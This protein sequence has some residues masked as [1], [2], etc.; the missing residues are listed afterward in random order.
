MNQPFPLKDPTDYDLISSLI[1]NDS[2]AA[3]GSTPDYWDG[4]I[5]TTNGVNVVSTVKSNNALPA[6][7]D[8][9]VFTVKFMTDSLQSQ[10]VLSALYDHNVYIYHCDPSMATGIGLYAKQGQYDYV[11]DLI[12]YGSSTHDGRAVDQVYG[13]GGSKNTPT[14]TCDCNVLGLSCASNAYMD[15]SILV[16]EFGHTVM[17]V[18]LRYG[19]PTLYSSLTGDIFDAYRSGV[20]GATSAYCGSTAH[21]LWAC[22]VQTWLVG[23][24]R[25]D[26]NPG[27]S[28]VDDIYYNLQPLYNALYNTFG[29]P[30]KHRIPSL[31]SVASLSE[32]TWTYFDHYVNSYGDASLK[33]SWNAIKY[34]GSATD[35]DSENDV[36]PTPTPPTPTP[37]PTNGEVLSSDF[38]CGQT[39]SGSVVAGEYSYH[40]FTYTGGGILMYPCGQTY[41]SSSLRIIDAYWNAYGDDTSSFYEASCDLSYDDS[42]IWANSGLV[43]GSSYW[44][45]VEGASSEDAG[46]YGVTMYCYDAGA[47]TVTLGQEQIELGNGVSVTAL[48]A[49]VLITCVVSLAVMCVVVKVVTERKME[50]FVRA[51]SNAKAQ[52][53]SKWSVPDKEES[54]EDQEIEVD[55]DMQTQR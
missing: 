2:A 7:L 6:A 36:T 37:P 25:S 45:I 28:T 31:T 24:A 55:V 46:Q 8:I 54:D 21:E 12:N 13:Y 18:G 42:V 34:T 14:T 23:T 5:R 40:A 50:A 30:A 4:A 52:S 10:S 48:V 27:I 11:S 43:V 39:V 41:F 38:G 22:G 19:N 35:D 47:L 26:V 53:A 20:S 33:G 1:N 3:L 9:G 15:S 49:A 51:Q 16:H 29:Q 44:L 17:D 32:N